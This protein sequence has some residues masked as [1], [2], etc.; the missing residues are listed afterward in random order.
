MSTATAEPTASG[1]LAAPPMPSTLSKRALKKQAKQQLNKQHKHEHHLRL[2]AAM[3]VE[4]QRLRKR[5]QCIAATSVQESALYSKLPRSS[6]CELF[7]A[8]GEAAI[9]RSV[10][11]QLPPGAGPAAP[12]QGDNRDVSAQARAG[13]AIGQFL[14]RAPKYDEKYASQE[15]S[16]L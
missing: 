11:F 6:E 10:L 16:L 7:S 5:L 12:V 13:R 15:L 14:W 1:S 4:A 3:L 2:H 8:L 9:Q